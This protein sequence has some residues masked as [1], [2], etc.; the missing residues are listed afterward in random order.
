ML[1]AAAHHDLLGHGPPS[2]SL[3]VHPRAGRLIVTRHADATEAHAAV[4]V[5]DS[6]HDTVCQPRT[7]NDVAFEHVRS[8][9]EAR[10]PMAPHLQTV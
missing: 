2:L 8:F 7:V 9:C 10:L 4:D 3:Y 1:S 5:A 6:H